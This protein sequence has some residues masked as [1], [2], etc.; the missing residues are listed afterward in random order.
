MELVKETIGRVED[1]KTLPGTDDIDDDDE[2]GSEIDKIVA[3]DVLAIELGERIDGKVDFE[4]EVE[5][6]DDA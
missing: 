4:L 2:L 5:T 6:E 3:A 1:F